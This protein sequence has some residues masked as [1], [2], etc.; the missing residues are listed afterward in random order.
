V[1][2]SWQTFLEIVLGKGYLNQ[3]RQLITE[4]KNRILFEK[5]KEII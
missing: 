3:R 1:G 2:G 4:F 5:K